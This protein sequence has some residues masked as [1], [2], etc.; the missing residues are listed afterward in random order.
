MLDTGTTSLATN[1][2][3]PP[4]VF[5]NCYLYHDEENVFLT[6]DDL[7]RFASQVANG[8]V[9]LYRFCIYAKNYFYNDNI[10]N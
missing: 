8:M 6:I 4:M 7:I 2:G 1:A 10:P 5:N 3:S 9:R